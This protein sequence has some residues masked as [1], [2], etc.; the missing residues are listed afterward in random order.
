MYGLY[1]CT[2]TILQN[3][4]C[5]SITICISIP[6][7]VYLKYFPRSFSIHT[8]DGRKNIAPVG[9]WF[10]PLFTTG[11]IHPKG[12]DRRTSEPSTVCSSDYTYM[13]MRKTSHRCDELRPLEE[14]SR[15]RVPFQWRMLG[16]VGPMLFHEKHWG[17]QKANTT[18]IPYIWEDLLSFCRFATCTIDESLEIEQNVFWNLCFFLWPQRCVTLDFHFG[19]TLKLW[20]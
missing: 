8:F 10:I 20:Q 5:V 2:D 15:S 16:P 6:I 9:R 18:Q 19:E 13:E 14:T 11:F 7:C 1:T 17:M 12:G 3:S 4:T